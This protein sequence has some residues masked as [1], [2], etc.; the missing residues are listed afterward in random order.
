MKRGLPWLKTV[1]RPSYVKARLL[2]LLQPRRPF[3]RQ[4]RYLG[5]DLL[6]LAN[7]AVG[8][9]L[10]TE[11]GYEELEMRHFSA[12]IRE[13]DVC[14]DVGGNI[15]IYSVLM[16]RKAARG[17]VHVFEPLSQYRNVTALNAWLNGLTNIVLHEGV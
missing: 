17:E 7:E 10:L 5:M 6:V 4:T 16:G 9:R 1:L 12:H 8:W 13:D 14:V 3:Y 15:G 2:G 11:H